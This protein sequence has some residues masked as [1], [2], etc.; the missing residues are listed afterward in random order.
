MST[1][2]CVKRVWDNGDQTSCGDP[3]FRKNLCFKHAEDRV[4]ELL[5]EIF[6]A[7]KA[8]TDKQNELFE[9]RGG[10]VRPEETA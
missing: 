8:L 7:K 10:V 6:K 3:V 4:V 5:E 1:E 9:L 2:R